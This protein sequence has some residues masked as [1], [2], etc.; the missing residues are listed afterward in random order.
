MSINLSSFS[1]RNDFPPDW[2]HRF[3]DRLQS[4]V[5]FLLPSLISH[6]SWIY[7]PITW[8]FWDCGRSFLINNQG[9]ALPW[10]SRMC[11]QG[12]K[13]QSDTARILVLTKQEMNQSSARFRS[14]AA[15]FSLTSLNHILMPPKVQDKSCQQILFLSIHFPRYT[16]N[17]QSCISRQHPCP[18]CVS[19]IQAEIP[20]LLKKIPNALHYAAAL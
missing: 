2:D 20:K 11:F 4:S 8:R 12:L 16:Q 10:L 15:S 3:N 7:S 17:I 6:F 18:I 1:N 14:S 5:Q 13:L 9:W 19:K